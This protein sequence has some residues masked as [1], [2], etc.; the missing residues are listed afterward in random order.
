[1]IYLENNKPS[2]M[3]L[4]GFRKLWWKQILHKKS[5]LIL[6]KSLCIIFKAITAYSPSDYEQFSFEGWISLVI[7]KK[8]IYF[9]RTKQAQNR[10]AREWY[11]FSWEEI[12]KTNWKYV[13][14]QKKKYIFGSWYTLIYDFKNKI[15]YVK[16][17]PRKPLTEEDRLELKR[18]ISILKEETKTL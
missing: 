15:V 12:F 2:D 14:P 6:T 18:I 1:M 16:E 7:N 9:N 10:G 5:Y 8:F 11:I 3:S 17:I 13:G 4:V